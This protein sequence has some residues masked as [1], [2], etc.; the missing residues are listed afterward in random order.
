ML[1]WVHRRNKPTPTGTH[2]HHNS[3]KTMSLTRWEVKM[4]ITLGEGSHPRKW[5]P[6]AVCDGLKKEVGEDVTDWEWV[7]IE[8]V[9]I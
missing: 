8:D 6:D 1:Q 4:V 7:H 9:T 3:F 5:I 2:V